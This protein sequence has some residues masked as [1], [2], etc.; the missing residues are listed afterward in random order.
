MRIDG[1]ERAAILLL[2]LNIACTMSNQ[3]ETVTSLLFHREYD[4]ASSLGCGVLVES[5]F[6]CDS[7]SFCL[8][9]EEKLMMLWS[10]LNWR[11]TA[12]ASNNKL[13]RFNKIAVFSLEHVLW[14][15]LFFDQ[16][17]CSREIGLR[18]QILSNGRL[19]RT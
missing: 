7:C 1:D 3:Y 17:I 14:W 6:C 5:L 9:L 12:I 8:K 2:P 15:C 4:I 19:S 18:R 13:C 16:S 11:S 10:D